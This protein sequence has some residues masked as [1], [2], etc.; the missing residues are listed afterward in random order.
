MS[1]RGLFK[2]IQTLSL[3]TK[4]S[5]IVVYY[6]KLNDSLELFVVINATLEKEVKEKKD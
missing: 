1:E 4:F 2:D 6:F 5:A 3:L